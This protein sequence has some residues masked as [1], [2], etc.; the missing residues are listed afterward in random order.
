MAESRIR[1]PANEGIGSYAEYWRV[2]TARL[3]FS[4][5]VAASIRNALA[6]E[7]VLRIKTNSLGEANIEN[8]KAGKYYLV[9]ASTLG[10]VGVVWSKG[11]DLVNGSNQLSLDLR[12]AA[13]AE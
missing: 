1:L 13:W 9:G 6:N 3:S 8:V 12:D 10:Q 4:S 11:V 5:G 2:Y 7:S